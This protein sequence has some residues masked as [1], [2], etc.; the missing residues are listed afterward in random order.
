M[1]APRY[2]QTLASNLLVA[3][4]LL[5]SMTSV[6]VGAASEKDILQ[7]AGGTG[8]D[9]V[10]FYLQNPKVS[11]NLLV[12][13]RWARADDTGK[14]PASFDPKNVRLVVPAGLR[15]RSICVDITSKDGRYTAENLYAVPPDAAR[16][17]RLDAKT[18]YEPVLGRYDI[19]SIAVMIR[20][21]PTC[22]AAEFGWI[23]PAVLVPHGA[24]I[25]AAISAVPA[26]VINVNADP[27]RVTL[28]LNP[29]DASDG[30]LEAKCESTAKGVSISYSTACTFRPATRLVGGEYNL[31]LEIKERFKT[32]PTDFHLLIVE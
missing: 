29:R 31:H 16:Q 5:L 6:P 11:G 24:D 12:G 18:K 19:D 10:D 23:I 17:P 20:T 28:T 15:V 32:V 13:V 3:A 27:E 8:A 1:V 9:Y 14:S 4:P 25:S 21:V 26:L 2:R 7:L 30:K 22:D